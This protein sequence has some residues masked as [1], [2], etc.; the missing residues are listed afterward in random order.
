MSLS[1]TLPPPASCAALEADAAALRLLAPLRFLG[2]TCRAKA[3][4]DAFEA[5]AM[6][7]L[8]PGASV[9]A[10]ADALLRVLSQALGRPL[11]LH[12]P[13]S[14][15]LSFDE[16]WLAALVAAA[17]RGDA[18]SLGFLTAHRIPRHMARQTVWLARQLAA[19]LA[20]TE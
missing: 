4:L 5:C 18:G 9:Q 7:S 3:R 8:D 19:G 12:A 16:R 15:D 1:E 17:G 14:T 13:G 11:K 10:H 6:L 20:E 2:R